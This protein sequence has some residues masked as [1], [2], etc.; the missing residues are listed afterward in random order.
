MR[1]HY[2]LVVWLQVPSS[3]EKTGCSCQPSFCLCCTVPCANPP[4]SKQ[5]HKFNMVSK[6]GNTRTFGLR[7]K[8][9]CT[10]ANNPDKFSLHHRFV[11]DSCSLGHC[12]I[13]YVNYA[14]KSC[15]IL[16]CHSA[17]LVQIHTKLLHAH[18]GGGSCTL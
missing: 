3:I 13:W 18:L 15:N 2:I 4:K 12:G 11:K 7:S 17:L 8:V 6:N 5:K 9:R 14:T 10:P 1:K 16:L